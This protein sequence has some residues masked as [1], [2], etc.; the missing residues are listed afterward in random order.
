M[1]NR[2]KPER[3]PSEDEVAAQTKKKDIYAALTALIFQKRSSGDRSV[4]TL[5]LLGKMLRNNPDI[6]TLWNYRR[7]ILLSLHPGLEDANTSGGGKLSEMND[8]AQEELQV[9]ADAIQRNP[10]CCKCHIYD[11]K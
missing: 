8:V 5:Q 11:V 6:Y 1:H 10:K 4:D 3:P 2:K 9:S 7:E